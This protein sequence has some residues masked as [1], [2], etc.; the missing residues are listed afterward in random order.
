[1]MRSGQVASNVGSRRD[2]SRRR[3]IQL[4]SYQRRQASLLG[5][6]DLDL[7]P[8]DCPPPLLTC[9]T[10]LTAYDE[11]ARAVASRDARAMQHLAGKFRFYQQDLERRATRFAPY[12]VGRGAWRGILGR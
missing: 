11:Y 10:V 4:S 1:M 8:G 7:P 12:S 9:P 6:V 2:F 3:R 5:Y